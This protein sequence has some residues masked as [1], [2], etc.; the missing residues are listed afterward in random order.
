M[1]PVLRFWILYNI[2]S[3]AAMVT[4]SIMFLQYIFP[5]FR[6]RPVARVVATTSEAEAE[7]R[8]Q[9]RPV[10]IRSPHD[11]LA[12]LGQQSRGRAT[13]LPIGTVA[14]GASVVGALL[15]VGAV[16]LVGHRRW[17]RRKARRRSTSVSPTSRPLRPLDPGGDG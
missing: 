13:G 15:L 10:P 4:I 1:N 9:L 2:F 17:Q 14:G 5:A 16:V 8:R 3:A 6:Q 12:V 11:A 7:R